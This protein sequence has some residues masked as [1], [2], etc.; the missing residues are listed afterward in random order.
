MDPVG[1]LAERVYGST[2][3]PRQWARLLSAFAIA[4]LV[5]AAVGIFGLLSYWVSQMRREIG[6]R[7]ALGAQ[8]R[9]IA[10]MVVTQGLL[11]AAF[12]AIV[13][14]VIAFAGQ[15][16]IQ[17]SLYGADGMDVGLLALAVAILLGVSATAAAIPAVRASRVDAMT[18]LRSD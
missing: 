9:T 14:V 17:S 13:G 8:R 6:V 16:L 7:V 3:Q 2:A 15:R 10:R 18:A 5:L 1:S 12:G 4:A 11:N